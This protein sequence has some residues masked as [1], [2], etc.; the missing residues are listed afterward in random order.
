MTECIVIFLKL[1]VDII[2]I[3]S[4]MHSVQNLCIGDLLNISI[5][6]SFLFFVFCIAIFM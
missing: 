6:F 3:H 4:Y 1:K 5:V 2:C